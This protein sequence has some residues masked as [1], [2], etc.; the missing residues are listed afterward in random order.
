MDQCEDLT[1]GDFWEP[2]YSLEELSLLTRVDLP[3]YYYV[4]PGTEGTESEEISG[5]DAE[6]FWEGDYTYYSGL[7]RQEGQ[8]CHVVYYVKNEERN[9]Y[10]ISDDTGEIQ[11]E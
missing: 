3:G 4:V 8:L 1:L 11:E 2:F 7:T 9:S 5:G 6:D 10:L